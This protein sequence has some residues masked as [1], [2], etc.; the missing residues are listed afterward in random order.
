MTL[1]E[2]PI[3]QLSQ[4][5]TLNLIATIV[6]IVGLFFFYAFVYSPLV[7]RLDRDIKNLRGLLLIFSDEVSRNT[8]AIINAGRDM[9]KDSQS[10]ASAGMSAGSAGARTSGGSRRH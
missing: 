5:N 4:Y 3:R 6:S 7:R 8:A 9:L 10:V 2:E 1:T